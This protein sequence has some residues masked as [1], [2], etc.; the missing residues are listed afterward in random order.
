MGTGHHDPT[1]HFRTHPTARRRVDERRLPL[2]R[3]A[4]DWHRCD[5]ADP[6]CRGGRIPASR[7][8]ITE[9]SGSDRSARVRRRVVRS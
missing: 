6:R 2:A 1:D 4:V 8:A 5:R 9:R 7:M 3:L